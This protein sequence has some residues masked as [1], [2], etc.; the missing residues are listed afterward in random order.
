M[1]MYKGLDSRLTVAEERPMIM[2][3]KGAKGEL[4]DV[5]RSENLL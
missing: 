4:G 1:A 5:V 3:P 2:G